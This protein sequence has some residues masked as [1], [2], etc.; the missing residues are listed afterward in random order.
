[1]A[2]ALTLLIMLAMM[3]SPI[4]FAIAATSRCAGRPPS[5]RGLRMVRMK[6][7]RRGQPLR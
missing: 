2:D 3:L 4:G 5:E 6:H 7:H 1:M